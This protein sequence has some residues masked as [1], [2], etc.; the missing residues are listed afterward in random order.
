MKRR[1]MTKKIIE[2]SGGIDE[3]TLLML[4][5]DGNA[6]DSSPYNRQPKRINAGSYYQG[7]FGRAIY[8]GPDLSA[9]ISYDRSWFVNLFRTG[10]Y[11]IDFW[12]KYQYGDG[13]WGSFCSIDDGTVNGFVCNAQYG[14][15]VQYGIYNDLIIGY[16][17]GMDDGDWHHVAF[18]SHSGTVTLYID[19]RAVDSGAT[20]NVSFPNQ[21]FVI[22]GRTIGTNVNNENYLDEFRISDIARWTSDFTPPVKPYE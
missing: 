6:V 17:S 12:Y 11:T 7:M 15:Y 3:H 19:G 2:E 4:H 8:I 21:D 5:F 1:V 10:E 18:V 16:S 9:Y 13:N 20:K 14:R 22:G